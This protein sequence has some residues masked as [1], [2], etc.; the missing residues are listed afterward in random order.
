[1]D[2][3]T[4]TKIE[5]VLDRIRIRDQATAE[6]A[7]VQIATGLSGAPIF[8]LVVFALLEGEARRLGDGF[9]IEAV[10]ESVRRRLRGSAPFNAP[11]W[12]ISFDKAFSEVVMAWRAWRG[13]K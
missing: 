1:M 13:A 8:D 9:S 2:I 11:L 10:V 12:D 4:I 5:R 6:I 7:A 3:E